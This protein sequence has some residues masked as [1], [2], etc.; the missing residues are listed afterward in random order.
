MFTTCSIQII[1]ATDVTDL[2]SYSLRYIVECLIVITAIL[3][4][5]ILLVLLLER[6]SWHY[7]VTTPT[8]LIIDLLSLGVDA[9]TR[10]FS[11]S[12]CIGSSRV[13]C[14]FPVKTIC[15][16]I[17]VDLV[18][19]SILQRFFKVGPMGSILGLFD[20]ARLLIDLLAL[21]LLHLVAI[22]LLHEGLNCI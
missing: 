12:V 3:V 4:K 7:T 13:C 2:L 20:R 14:G 22:G 16:Y 9:T 11:I 19:I 6:Q 15:W 5:L 17:Y 18:I 1:C 8:D 21:Q 10:I